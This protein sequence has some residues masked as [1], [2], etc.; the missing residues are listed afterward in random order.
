MSCVLP[1]S[2]RSARSAPRFAMAVV[3][4]AWLAA[5]APSDGSRGTAGATGAAACDIREDRPASTAG[6][7][8]A[9]PA[10]GDTAREA[11]PLA[12]Q[13]ARSR[14]WTFDST[15]PGAAPAGLLFGRTGRGTP[16][17]WLVQA[18]PDAPSGPHV[19]VQTD[20]DRT[21]TRYP[22]AIAAAPTMRDGAVTTRCKIVS[23]R[24]D[25][26]CGVVFRYRDA[27]N[28]YVARANALEQNIR[29]YTVRNGRRRELAS[30]A[31]SVTRG[32][33]HELEAEAQGD[34]IRVLWNGRP[35]LEY[36]DDTFPGAGC[37]GVWTK[38]D[39]YTLYDDLTITPLEPG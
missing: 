10:S 33:W 14:R 22:V 12:Q 5:C 3:A 2:G 20:T 1:A 7:V 31:E 19:L 18:A 23:G 8:G 6:G 36:R 24:V 26:A 9:A 39:A 11:S 4:V 28:Y 15:G 21:S 34:R 27:D 37:A 32:A 16:A 17:R 29:L 13:P 25:Q 38:A 35:V 30:W